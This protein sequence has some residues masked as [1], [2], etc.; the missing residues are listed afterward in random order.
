MGEEC[1]LAGEY[2][3]GEGIVLTGRWNRHMKNLVVLARK[4]KGGFYLSAVPIPTFYVLVGSD[5]IVGAKCMQK[6]FNTS[7]MKQKKIIRIHA[8]KMSKLARPDSLSGR[9][10][11]SCKMFTPEQDVLQGSRCGTIACHTN[12][13]IP[14]P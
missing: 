7:A 5:S 9:R 2:L 4:N 3:F 10:F 6:F 11:Y 12:H 8:E 14:P 13:T 1:L